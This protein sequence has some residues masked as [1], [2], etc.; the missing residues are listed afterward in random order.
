MKFESVAKGFA[1]KN[2]PESEVE[3]VG[4]L[5][6]ELVAPYHDKALAHLAEH[7]ELPGF[8]PGKVPPAMALQ[9]VGE[10][11]VLEEAVELFVK[12]FYPELVE[13][14]KIDAVGRPDI[15]VTKLAPNNPVGLVVRTS[16]YPAVEVTKKWKTLHEGAAL[17]PALPATDEE[18]A[19]TLEQLRQSRKKD[20]TVPELSD[21]FAKSVGAFETLEQLKEQ[22]KKGIGEEKERAAKDSRRGKLI[23]KLLEE[24]PLSGPKIFIES[25]IEKM[26]AQMREDVQKFGMTFEQ[27][28][29]RVSKTED[30]IR[31]ELRDQATKRAKL[32]LVLNKLADEEK[33]EIDEK[34]IEEEMKHALEHFPEAKPGLVRIHIETVLRNEKVLKLLEGET[35]KA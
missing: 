30:G 10:I 33:V 24:T 23:E 7:L 8:R 4:E 6:Y 22:I 29:E 31:A 35:E 5:P 20:D 26:M 32:Q 15:R 14:H 27:Y 11:S 34:V 19:Q 3:L 16:V 9:K 13:L 21:E 28:L 1:L 25:E 12:D 17:E 18:V 2:L